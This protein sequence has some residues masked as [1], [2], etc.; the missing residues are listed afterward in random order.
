MDISD[1][2]E[3][4]PRIRASVA[5]LEFLPNVPESILESIKN[6][7]PLRRPGASG[8]RATDLTG[9]TPEGRIL[10]EVKL[11]L[12]DEIT[13][14]TNHHMLSVWDAY[15]QLETSTDYSPLNAK[16]W[17]D[18]LTTAISNAL[19][20]E[21][22]WAEL[23]PRVREKEHEKIIRDM[24]YLARDIKKYELDQ[25]ELVTGMVDPN[26]G[27]WTYPDYG[28]PLKG[29]LGKNTTYEDLYANQTGI[30]ISDLLLK[31]ADKLEQEKRYLKPLTKQ[32]KN[33]KT[34]T[35][36]LSHFY[37]SLAI[38]HIARY[39]DPHIP[40]ILDLAYVFFPELE[41][42]IDIDETTV[43]ASIKNIPIAN[44]KRP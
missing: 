13:L 21:S 41:Q 34:N 35:R 20:K 39:G 18:G 40:I 5:D 25:T 8:A 29:N 12:E 17:G 38:Y 11:R 43:R 10:L 24:R 33:N 3:K 32:S 9:D 22:P 19:H 16:M 15:A 42:G 27:A 4:S 30:Q 36:K 14:A 31:H 44:T 37:R 2:F 1:L 7:F 26:K 6:V 23:T 28:M